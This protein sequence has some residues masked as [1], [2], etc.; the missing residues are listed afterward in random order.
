ME[1]KVL[2]TPLYGAGA[3]GALSTLLEVRGVRFLLDCGWNDAYDP[4]LLAPLI[5]VC[6]T[7]CTKQQGSQFLQALHRLIMS[8]A[9]MLHVYILFIS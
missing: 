6:Y 7:T 5:K 3:S 2:V 9:V 8:T 4:A 1:N